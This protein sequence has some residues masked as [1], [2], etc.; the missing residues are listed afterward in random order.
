MEMKIPNNFLLK[1]KKVF[2][3]ELLNAEA[4]IIER[5]LFDAKEVHRYQ[6]RF[7]NLRD[8]TLI[9]GSL[10]NRKGLL[11]YVDLSKAYYGEYIINGT[12]NKN[13]STRWAPDDFIDN[14]MKNNTQWIIERLRSA[15]NTAT[16]TANR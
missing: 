14:A 5:L 12:H 13:G 6:H 11:L 1:Y 4:D 2:K 3:E 16:H 9:K 10:L 7:K 15:T 8:A